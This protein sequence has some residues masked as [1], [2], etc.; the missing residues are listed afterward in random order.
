[1]KSIGIND[2]VYNRLIDYKNTKALIKKKSKY[3]FTDAIKDLLDDSRLLS[4]WMKG[5]KST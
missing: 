5:K 4:E 2:E 1:M 3:S